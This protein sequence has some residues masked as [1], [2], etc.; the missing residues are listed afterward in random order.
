MHQGI[1]WFVKFVMFLCLL[2]QEDWKTCWRTKTCLKSSKQQLDNVVQ[3]TCMFLKVLF[4]HMHVLYMLIFLN[5]FKWCTLFV[6]GM[7]FI[8]VNP[9]LV[10]YMS[11]LHQMWSFYTFI[12]IKNHGNITQKTMIFKLNSWVSKFWKIQQ[13]S[14]KKKICLP[15]VGFYYTMPFHLVNWMKC[16]RKQSG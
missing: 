12:K 9:F 5:K 7:E 2:L 10:K 1:I 4:D 11:Y 16:I 14:L 13:Y 15:L 3:K 8:G 6:L